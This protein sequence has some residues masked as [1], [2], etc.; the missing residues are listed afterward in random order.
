MALLVYN[1]RARVCVLC[2][3]IAYVVFAFPR[4]MNH[5]TCGRIACFIR[6]T[7]N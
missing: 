7:E 4:S 2:A 6:S 1:T 3:A 5:D